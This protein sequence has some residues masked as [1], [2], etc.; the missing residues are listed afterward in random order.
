M[1]VLVNR[2]TA[3]PLM[4]CAMLIKK[5]C[6]T[7]LIKS[8]VR[9]LRLNGLTY[10]LLS[11][12]PLQELGGDEQSER[13]PAGRHRQAG[14]DHPEQP[15]TPGG[16]EQGVQPAQPQAGGGLGGRPATGQK[17]GHSRSQAPEPGPFIS[18]LSMIALEN[19]T[20]SFIKYNC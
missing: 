6:C 13:G 19:S 7:A 17:P 9:A 8:A 5:M 4:K 18:D 20:A 2:C 14:G 3:L 1:I 16:Q 11:P 12:S 15:V 10:R